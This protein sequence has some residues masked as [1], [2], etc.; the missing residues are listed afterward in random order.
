MENFRVHELEDLQLSTYMICSVSKSQEIPNGRCALKKS[1]VGSL[2]LVYVKSHP[3]AKTV[4]WHQHT[5]LFTKEPIKWLGQRSGVCSTGKG[6]SFQQMALS[7]APTR[8][9]VTWA[10]AYTAHK[11]KSKWIESQR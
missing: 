7:G 2:A 5:L 9:Q 11:S 4:A 8:K 3:R 1:T 6:W 10:V